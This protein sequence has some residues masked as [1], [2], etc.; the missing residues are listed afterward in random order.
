[1]QDAV[2]LWG[3]ALS[4]GKVQL[5]V[6]CLD[7]QRF[8]VPLAQVH[9]VIRAVEP[10]PLPQAPPSVLGVIDLQGTVVPVLNV[11]GRFGFAEREI[12]LEDQFIVADTSTR[13][14]ALLVDGTNGVIERPSQ[15]IFAIKKMVDQSEQIEGVIRLEDGLLLIHDLERFLSAS[16]ESALDGALTGYSGHGT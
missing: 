2:N 6:F 15:E 5:L 4:N 3:L 8:G 1:M 9:R 12:T 14:V 10:T 7:A 13:T 11:R 16:E